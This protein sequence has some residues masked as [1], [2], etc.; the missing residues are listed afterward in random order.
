MERTH[1]GSAEP[2]IFFADPPAPLADHHTGSTQSVKFYVRSRRQHPGG[3]VTLTIV[4]N[5]R[6]KDSSSCLV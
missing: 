3:D 4:L 2:R 1:H 5:I 6:V